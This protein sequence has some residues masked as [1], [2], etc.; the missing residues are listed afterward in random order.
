M[1][2]EH[3]FIQTR[4]IKP[5]RFSVSGRL[6]FKDGVS[7]PYESALERDFLLYF[8]YLPSIMELISQPMRIPFI[9]NGITYYYTPDFFLRFNDGQAMLVEVKPK[10]KW[11]GN[12]KDCKEKWKAAIRFCKEN[13][14]VFHI[15]DEDRI[16]HE[17]FF[18]INQIQR[19]KRLNCDQQDV[20]AVLNQVKLMGTTTIDYLLSRFF[21]G[22]LYR[23]KGLQTLYYL[24]ATKQL[25]CNWFS[26][27]NEFT[28]VWGNNDD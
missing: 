24:L 15:Y 17:A 26:A 14:Y 12:W 11:Q 6:P 3:T 22:S 18:N 19:Y 23:M 7:I 1:K 25:H 9:K 10:R 21:M 27:L 5:T 28:E 4:K 16:Y 8:T 2:K 13:G 20:S